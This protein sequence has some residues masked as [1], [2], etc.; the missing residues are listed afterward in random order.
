MRKMNFDKNFR[1]ASDTTDGEKEPRDASYR[2]RAQMQ[3][4]GKSSLQKLQE[5]QNQS[6][7]LKFT[8]CGFMINENVI[9]EQTSM[10][11]VPRRA[12]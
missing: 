9:C 5:E 8:R 12:S 7:L 11:G 6:P 1:V 4:E 10:N 2:S 3:K